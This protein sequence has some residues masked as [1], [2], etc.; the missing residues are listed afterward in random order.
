[1]ITTD[2]ASIESLYEH[3]KPIQAIHTSSP[4]KF[5]P[6]L[7]I[8][9]LNCQIIVGKK[10]AWINMLNT[11]KPDPIIA[12]ETWLDDTISNTEHESDN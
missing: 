10:G 2:V 8:I 9:N 3:H 5:E 1:M 4:R 6:P 11:F 7:R 12:I